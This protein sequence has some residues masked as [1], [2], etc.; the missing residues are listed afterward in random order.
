MLANRKSFDEAARH[1][2]ATRRSVRTAPFTLALLRYDHFKAFQRH[3]G[4][5]TGDQ[6][7]A[8]VAKHQ[9]AGQ[10]P[11]PR[12]AARYG[13]RNSPCSPP[14]EGGDRLAVALR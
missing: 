14:A 9:S 3:L 5:Q 12:L 8:I 7:P 6:L 13:V 10:A 1:A 11:P 4:T 2:H